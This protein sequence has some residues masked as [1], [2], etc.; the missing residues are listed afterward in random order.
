MRRLAVLFAL[1]ALVIVGCSRA[2]V[3]RL[4]GGGATFIEPL[5]L[6]WQRVYER[7]TGVQV[8]YTGTGS[9]NGVQQM[10]NGAILFGCTDLPMTT[11]ARQATHGSR[12]DVIHIPLA[13]GGVVPI[14]HLDGL[15]VDPPLRFSGEVLAD[16]FLGNLTRWSDPALAAL[17]RGV[18]L[19]D[20]P[21]H[22]VSRSDPS[23]TS[24]V[25]AEYLA[26][27][28]PEAWAA[29]NMGEGL[30]VAFA[31]GVRQKGNPGVAGEVGRLNGAIG[32]VEL[33]F[34][35]HM[36]EHV[37]AGAVRNR[38][39]GFVIASPKSVAAAAASLDN[40]PAD[41]C[42]SIVDASGPGSYPI[43]GADWAVFRRRLPAE[44]G[45]QLVA[46]LRWVTA[47]S[48]GQRFAEP[49]GYAPL[50]DRIVEK[51]GPAL[52]SVEFE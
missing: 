1:H 30:S 32:Y 50:P 5:M 12:D 19:P 43:G 20:L 47:P 8:D 46:F 49:L 28:R 39:G 6:K 48:Q 35:S 42:F 22:V 31:V 27:M 9:G 36:T 51:I 14:Y 38:A 52:E 3:P 23:G 4:D 13:L 33:A 24:A 11:E 40:I 34:A 37:A 26:K 10:L 17:N 29:R 18:Q 44:R 41:L 15:P 25:F 21:I 2:D 7:E 16:I 45:R